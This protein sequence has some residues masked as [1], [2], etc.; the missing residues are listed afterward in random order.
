MQGFKSVILTVE[1]NRQMRGKAWLI[2]MV[3]FY[4]AAGTNHFINAEFYANLM[5]DW[6][7]THALLIQLSGVVEITLALLLL[8]PF[9]QQLAAW[10]ISIMLI[11]FLLSIHIPMALKF[12]GWDN[13][14]WWAAVVRVPIQYVLF[15][16]ARVYTRSHPVNVWKRN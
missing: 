7:P 16:W 3:L 1:N 4:I 14:T 11:V 10:L 9:T 13:V 12:E 2:I 6:L 5:P 8:I 15:M